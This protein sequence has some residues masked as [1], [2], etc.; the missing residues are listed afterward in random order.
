MIGQTSKNFKSPMR[1]DSTGFVL[2]LAATSSL[3]T[4][5]TCQ[6]APAPLTAEFPLHLEDHLDAAVITGSEAPSDVPEVV[7]WS[8]DEPQTDWKTIV[9]PRPNIKPAQVRRT[10]DSLRITLT[11]ANS[12]S[13]EAHQALARRFTRAE[14]SPLTP[15]QLRTSRSL[16]YIQ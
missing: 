5:T 13:L 7:E 15:E 12:S 3:L 8:F 6:D 10:K 9:P 14:D 16:G 11:R 1:M 4:L 2:L